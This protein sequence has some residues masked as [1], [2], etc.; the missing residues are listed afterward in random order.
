[1]YCIKWFGIILKLFIYKREQVLLLFRRMVWISFRLQLYKQIM[2]KK[3]WILN[4]H[5]VKDFYT[6]EIQYNIL[7]LWVVT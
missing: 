1:M 4:Y 3:E 2:F 7:R 6:R 5:Y